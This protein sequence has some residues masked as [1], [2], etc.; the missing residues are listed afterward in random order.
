MTKLNRLIAVC[1]LGLGIFV[2]MITSAETTRDDIRAAAEVC[3]TDYYDVVLSIRNPEM[4]RSYFTDMFTMSTCQ[5]NDVLPLYEEYEAI[6][7]NFRSDA[8]NCGTVENYNS[9]KAEYELE[10]KRILLEV[11]FIRNV[12]R[13]SKVDEIEGEKELILASLYGDMYGKFVEGSEDKM[14][15]EDQ[16]DEMYAVW[17][18]KYSDSIVNYSYCTEGA[19]WELMESWIDFQE[20]LQSL[21][22]EVEKP[23]RKSFKDVI[24]PQVEISDDTVETLQGAQGVVDAAKNF[25]DRMRNKE[26]K[27]QVDEEEE[28]QEK[29]GSNGEGGE[30]DFPTTFSDYIEQLKTTTSDDDITLASQARMAEYELLYG[31]VGATS[32]TNIVVTLDQMNQVITNNNIQDFP[33]IRESLSEIHG[34]QCQ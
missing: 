34:K 25:F 5:L 32:T 13:T 3:L 27:E 24:T 1:L 33:A 31:E 10:L 16:F 20:T 19:M 23:E 7:D 21:D 28:K 14:V 12:K 22:F 15:T 17:T 11:H 4:R 8:A 2:P 6:K 30:V 29:S 9:N 26:E 18:E